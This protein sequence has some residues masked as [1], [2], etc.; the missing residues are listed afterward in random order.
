MRAVPLAAV[1]AALALAA[2][3]AAVTNPQVAG[4]QVALRA[5]GFYV[6]PIDGVSGPQTAHAIRLF[7]RTSGLVADGIAGVSTRRAFGRLGRPL[8]GTR[9]MRRGHVGWDV[10]VLQFLLRERGAGRVVDGYY[11]PETGRAVRRFQRRAGLLV[12]GIAGPATI[13][14]LDPRRRGSI[15]PAVPPAQ[16]PVRYV[17][18]AGDSLTA[19]AERHGTTVRA[20][21][22]A[23]RLDPARVLLVGTVLRIPAPVSRAAAVPALIDR[24]AAHYGVDPRLAR[25]LAWYESGFQSHVVSPAGALGVMQITPPT[26]EF[27]ETVLLGRRVPKTTDGNVRVGVA[28]L[29]H[30][31]R[32]FRGDERLAL[33]AYYQGAKA[34]RE[35]GLLPGTQTY[36]S[37]ILALRGRV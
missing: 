17:A 19:I 8:F 32:E 12:D 27:V 10:A 6:G 28:F 18:R 3:A 4:L 30:L 22:S 5:H 37:G 2:P 16:P 24:W 29:R 15:P 25:A 26:W 13:A 1:A 34:V 36:V 14:A 20:L 33:A 11:G 7:Q 31:L 21:A 9:T 23:N 35:H